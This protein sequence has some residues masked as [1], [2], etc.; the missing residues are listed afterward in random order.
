[1]TPVHPKV[2]LVDTTQF[3]PSSPLFA[4]ALARA[5]EAGT[6]E[7][8]FVDEGP[9]VGRT[10]ASI[11]RRVVHRIRPWPHKSLRDLHRTI[12]SRARA[13]AA[14][15]VLVV[16]GAHLTVECL[17]EL[18]SSGA[19]LVNFTTDDPFNPRTSSPL[20]RRTLPLYDIVCSPRHANLTDLKDLGVR[21]V[22]F[23]PF[24]YKPEVHFEEVAA[25]SS[26][27]QRY[28][29]DVCF[30]GAADPDRLV[31]F[32]ALIEQ[33]PK[34]RLSL[35]GGFWNRSRRLAPFWRGFATGREFRLAVSGAA[36]SVNLVRRANRDDHVMRTFE[37][38]ACGGCM[39]TEATPTHRELFQ[40]GMEAFF[41]DSPNSMVRNVRFL[42]GNEAVRRRAASAARARITATGNTYDDRLKAMLAL[43]AS[44][45][46]P[47]QRERLASAIST[48]MTVA[49]VRRRQLPEDT[50]DV[51]ALTINVQASQASR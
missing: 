10:S 40:E 47:P 41:F 38:P 22:H 3:Y 8:A 20:W 7:G 15:V 4:E 11:L 42:L 9:A 51:E 2:L 21:C 50:S 30:I 19:T 17:T 25:N 31:Y 14:D 32:E 26:E 13:I 16:K 27:R 39:L 43:A 33:M 12:V 48:P 49:A 23:V 24:G 46:N 36:V 37:I 6:L 34:V 45:E 1:M 5:D 28:D 18:K 44:T 35:Y 29:A